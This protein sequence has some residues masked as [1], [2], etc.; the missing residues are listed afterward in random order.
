[1]TLG[2]PLTHAPFLL[3]NDEADLRTKMTRWLFPT[4]WLQF[5]VIQSEQLKKIN[6]RE[7]TPPADVLGPPGGLFSYFLRG[8][9]CCQREFMEI[10]IDFLGRC[11]QR[12]K[13]GDRSRSLPS[14]P[15]SFGGPTDLRRHHAFT[16]TRVS[17]TEFRTLP[18]SVEFD[19]LAPQ[20]RPEQFSLF[21]NSM[22]V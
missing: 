19:L 11:R 8:L 12:F 13:R 14:M 9:Q 20:T 18:R 15:F 2:S 1:M 6:D 21:T 10:S 5:E 7:G 16:V 17:N 3:A 4:N 22:E